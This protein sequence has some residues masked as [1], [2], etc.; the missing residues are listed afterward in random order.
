LSRSL[1]RAKADPFNQWNWYEVSK[2]HQITDVD[3]MIELAGTDIPQVIEGF[4]EYVASK[5]RE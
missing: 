1:I 3:A 4:Y 5:R 2:E